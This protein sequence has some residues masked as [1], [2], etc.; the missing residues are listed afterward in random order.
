MASGWQP[1]SARWTGPGPSIRLMS[2]PCNQGWV[3]ILSGRNLFRPFVGIFGLTSGGIVTA[4][5]LRA[6]LGGN[7]IGTVDCA[8]IG[9]RLVLYD[10]PLLFFLAGLFLGKLQALCVGDVFLVLLLGFCCPGLCYGVF[11]GGETPVMRAIP[12]FPC[13]S[14]VGTDGRPH[15]GPTLGHTGAAGPLYKT[16]PHQASSH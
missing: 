2:R 4:S 6:S 7:G 5:D 8:S 15:L 9:F 13:S 14:Q 10:S 3:M 12:L 11:Q 1:C 16:A